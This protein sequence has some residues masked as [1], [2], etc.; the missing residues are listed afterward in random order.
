M[1]ELKSSLKLSYGPHIRYHGG[2]ST[3]QIMWRVNFSLIPALLWAV[4]IFG[5][6][7]LL[8]TL[9]SVIGALLGEY[10]ICIAIKKPST[11]GD[12]SAVCTGIL[13]AFTL[14][15]G[16]PFYMPLVGAFLAI[17]LAKGVFGGLG[18][19]IF[20]VALIGRAIM[21]ASFPV[22]MTT[23]W[24]KPRF[25][26]IMNFDAATMATPLAVL[27]K[28][29]LDAALS[30]ISKVDDAAIGG[31]SYIIKLIFGLRPGS[32][33]EVSVVLIL[34]GAAYLF[35]KRIIK[36]TIPVSVIVGAA[37]MGFF[38]SSPVIQLVGGGLWLGAFYMAT[39]Y[40]TSPATFKA[41][42][43]FGL[44]VGILTGL[45]RNFGGYPEGICYAILLMNIMT[46]ALND[47]F[48]PRKFS[49]RAVIHE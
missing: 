14:P 12:G 16:V 34:L 1:S 23:L 27:K 29:G 32:I 30:L 9:A 44:G 26:G 28:D 39:D 4:F 48:K 45:I 10:L 35:Y 43:I 7:P 33:G 3:A 11:L 47:W 13:L 5:I 38:S 15:P 6:N 31:G 49:E 41:Q 37:I 2:L 22:A 8:V 20:N 40:V 36:L 46:P 18:H 21:M 17:I 42:I 19:N 24:S 25:F